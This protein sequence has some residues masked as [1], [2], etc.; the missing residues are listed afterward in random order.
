M[1][2]TL[3]GHRMCLRPTKQCGIGLSALV[4]LLR[5]GPGKHSV[6]KYR[7][8]QPLIAEHPV[9]SRESLCKRWV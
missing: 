2:V 8:W 5:S 4:A 3:C 9:I 1:G 6:S 7:V